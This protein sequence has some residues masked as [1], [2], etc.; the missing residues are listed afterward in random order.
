MVL[1]QN[2]QMMMETWN[3]TNGENTKVVSD[4]IKDMVRAHNIKPYPTRHSH[5]SRKDI[6]N[7]ERVYL[8]AELSIARMHHSFL[9]KH[10]SDYIAL[11]QENKERQMRHEVTQK[12]RKP[13][14]SEH[15]YVQRHIC[16]RI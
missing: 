7:S 15:N 9:E 16:N 1:R 4:A 14:T 2:F 10:D 5:Y 8:P 3:Q 13:L 12:L 11:E 6:Y